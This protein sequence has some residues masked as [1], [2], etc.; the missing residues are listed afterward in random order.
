MLYI[1]N[2]NNNNIEYNKQRK[3]LDFQNNHLIFYVE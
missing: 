2:K 1:F 3:R